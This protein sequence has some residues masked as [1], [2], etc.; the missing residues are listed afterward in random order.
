MLKFLRKKGVMKKFLWVVAIGIIVMFG[1]GG[2]SYLLKGRRGKLYAGKIFDQ[3]IPIKEFERNYKQAYIQAMIRYG[4][5]FNKIRQFLNLEAE[6]WDRIIILHEAQ[7]R[8]IKVSDQ[9][10]IEAIQSYKFFQ[11]D[12]HFDGELYNNVLAYGF[13]IKSRDFEE[14]I[15]DSLK[16]VK[17]F[18]EETSDID[19]T[20]QELLNAYKLKN[21]KVQV[22]YA[23]FEGEK[24]MD[25]VVYDEIQAK[26]YYHS[27]KNDFLV[28]P[29]VNVKYV[30][31]H[32]PEGATE[33]EKSDAQN[34][35]FAIEE[36][37]LKDPNLDAIAGKHGLKVEESGFFNMEQPNL[38]IGWS[39]SVLQNI[40]SMQ[41]GEISRMLE[42]PKGFQF[43]QLLEIKD[44]HIPEYIQAKDKVKEAWDQEEAKKIAKREAEK[45]L[46]IIL[47]EANKYK[48]PDFAK[49]ASDLNLKIEQTPVFTRG[50]YLP[51]IGISKDFQDTSFSLTDEKK[52]SHVVETEKGHCIL[53]LDSALP[54]EEDQFAAQKEGFREEI[55]QQRK[56]A[57]FSNFIS[58]LRQK[59]RLEDNIAKLMASNKPEQRK[60]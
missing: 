30:Q 49:I 46:G 27:H 28:P 12:G 5:E 23:L 45:Y 8:N 25:E 4:N 10:V 24:H 50:Q 2:Q 59:A 29:S 16:F 33:E 32:F 18:E 14:G 37:L 41:Q 19:V 58:T 3:K 36:G 52:I 38:E 39:F 40:F 20:N 9:E 43:I 54:V 60:E 57:S 35:A 1:F 56:N 11:R 42:T 13:K 6:T 15:R 53:H 44:A 22:S 31:V 55:L 26:N 47:E 48:R 34:K 21:E 7:E 17:L 51:G